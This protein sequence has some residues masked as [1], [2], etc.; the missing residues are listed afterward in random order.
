VRCHWAHVR[1]SAYVDGELR[2]DE[3]LR[4]REH[5]RTC[6]HCARELEDIRAIKAMVGA[7][8]APEP[9]AGFEERLRAAVFAAPVRRRSVPLR[10]G[11]VATSAAV[12]AA[13]TFGLLQWIGSAPVPVSPTPTAVDIRRDQ[14]FTA[15]IDPLG[16]A[17]PIVTVSNGGR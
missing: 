16:G 17:S 8:G 10:L 1:I 14:V 5:L 7:M 13:V 11:W 2:G 12:A 6:A 9:A 3:T 4:L 15:G